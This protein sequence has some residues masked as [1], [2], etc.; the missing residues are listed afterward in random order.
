MH[1]VLERKVVM[2]DA[3]RWVRLARR[4]VA[5]LVKNGIIIVGAAYVALPLSSSDIGRVI[6]TFAAIVALW[7]VLPAVLCELGRAKPGLEW[8]VGLSMMVKVLASAAAMSQ[9]AVWA[10]R[11]S[12]ALLTLGVLGGLWLL[13]FGVLWRVVPEIMVPD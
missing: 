8:L 5:M 10:T 1:R 13:W 12:S 2:G 11:G 6:G 4:K 7:D 3:A 9:L